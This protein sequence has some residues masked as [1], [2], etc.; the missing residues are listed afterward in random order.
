MAAKTK[1]NEEIKRR[2]SAGESLGSL[3]KAFDISPSRV[4]QLTNPKVAAAVRRYAL[5]KL[6]LDE[7]VRRALRKTW[8]SDDRAI[9]MMKWI[10]RPDSRAASATS[11]SVDD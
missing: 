6:F 4:N 8:H 2:R 9:A 3:A 7:F 5:K 10:S 1:R 11:R